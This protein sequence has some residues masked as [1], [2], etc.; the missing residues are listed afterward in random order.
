MIVKPKV[1]QP[2][3]VLGTPRCF[4]ISSSSEKVSDRS[5]ATGLGEMRAEFLALSFSAIRFKLTHE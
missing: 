4:S 1:H 2:A 3:G 5:D